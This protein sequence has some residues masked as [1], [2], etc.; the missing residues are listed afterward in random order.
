MVLLAEAVLLLWQTGGL[1]VLAGAGLV[2][3]S[4]GYGDACGSWTVVL[5]LGMRH[6]FRRQVVQNF[7]TGGK[8]PYVSVKLR[9]LFVRLAVFCRL[10]LYEGRRAKISLV[11]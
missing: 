7:S 1:T 11:F 2:D 3:G 9:L 4:R 8:K 10:H 6:L 5:P